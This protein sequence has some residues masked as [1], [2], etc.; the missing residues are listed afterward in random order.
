MCSVWFQ[1]INWFNFWQKTIS[2]YFWIRFEE[3]PNIPF[4]KYKK[5]SKK[6]INKTWRH[7]WLVT[8]YQASPLN[9]WKWNHLNVFISVPKTEMIPSC[10]SFSVVGLFCWFSW[11]IELPTRTRKYLYEIC[12][13]CK[14]CK[15]LF[16][17]VL[18][19][20]LCVS[21]SKIFWLQ[22]HSESELL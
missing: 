17:I 6:K 1:K 22:Y 8:V 3:A 4:W 7:F 12:V 13:P 9:Q 5:R 18:C 21:D 11:E 16:R 15:C 20:G 19:V 14:C 2:T 10:A